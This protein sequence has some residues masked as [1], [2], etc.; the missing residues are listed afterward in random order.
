MLI[1]KENQFKECKFKTYFLI[2]N[3][4]LTITEWQSSRC[5]QTFFFSIQL[6]LHQVTVAHE[7]N[8]IKSNIQRHL[9]NIKWRK[10][11]NHLTKITWYWVL[12]CA[13]SWLDSSGSVKWTISNTLQT[14]KTMLWYSCEFNFFKSQN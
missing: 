10:T 8:L 13:L 3:C 6:L 2:I 14:S 4:L 5:D 11:K 9:I 1:F 12:Y 7:Y